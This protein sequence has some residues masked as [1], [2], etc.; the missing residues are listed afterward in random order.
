M[1]GVFSPSFVII[2][3]IL[4]IMFAGLS[5]YL[6]TF[7]AQT[8]ISLFRMHAVKVCGDI[9][10]IIR[11]AYVNSRSNI[12]M[13]K[14][15]YVPQGDV[16][17]T[18]KIGCINDTVF[19]KVESSKGDVSCYDYLNC[20]SLNISGLLTPGYKCIKNNATNI[21]VDECGN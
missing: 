11:E 14:P 16:L 8:S 3:A 9:L 20:S 2:I 13:E 17:Y 12:T 10:D 18:A 6:M 7:K 1:L 4:L 21:W 19:V 15:I 5:Y